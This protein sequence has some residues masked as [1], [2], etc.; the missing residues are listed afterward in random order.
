MI[1]ALLVAIV[2]ECVLLPLQLAH[3]RASLRLTG[4][5]S[6]HSESHPD[7]S[8]CSTFPPTNV[9]CHC[10]GCVSIGIS[11]PVVGVRPCL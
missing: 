10:C 7:L 11:D 3:C 5:L 9:E 1:L 8:N 2:F 6:L 4:N